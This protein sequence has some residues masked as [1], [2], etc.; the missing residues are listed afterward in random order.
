LCCYYSYFATCHRTFI[1]AQFLNDFIFTVDVVVRMLLKDANRY[2]PYLAE[3]VTE[4]IIDRGQ[5]ITYIE[6]QNIINQYLFKRKYVRKIMDNLF[7][8]RIEV[9]HDLLDLLRKIQ[10]NFYFSISHLLI[11]SSYSRLFE[12][13]G[14]EEQNYLNSRI[15]TQLKRIEARNGKEVIIIDYNGTHNSA[16][17]KDNIF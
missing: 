11:V 17:E 5:N 1:E 15:I 2:G 9:A 14:K 8:A 10:F 16:K 7:V 3:L 4:R 13:M 6:N 12:G